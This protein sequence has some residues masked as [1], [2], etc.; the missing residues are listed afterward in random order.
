MV[1]RWDYDIVFATSSRLMTAVLGAWIARRK[2]ARLYLDIR[3]IFVDTIQ[4]VAPR[5]VS[6]LGKPLFSAMERWAIQRADTVNLVSP[7]FADY[8]SSRYP[9]QRFSFFTNGIDEEFLQVACRNVR[10]AAE[11]EGARTLSV[12]YAGNVGEG[13]GLHLII[14]EIA[15]RI[16]SDVRIRVIGDGGRKRALAVALYSA[17]ITNVDLLPPMSR[18]KL[19]E[20]YREADILF[21]HLNDYDAF[22]KVLPSKLFEYAAL[23]KPIWAGVSG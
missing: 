2:R 10:V 11:D 13:Q 15:K 23:G 21:L 22:K 5:M 20:A 14:P 9:N 12:V 4:D 18:N 7:A 19:I 3:D 8:F 1:A 17:G 6:L 16:G